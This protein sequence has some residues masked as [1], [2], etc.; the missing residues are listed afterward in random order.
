LEVPF[1]TIIFRHRETQTGDMNCGGKVVCVTGASGYIASWIVKLLLLRGYTVNATVRDPSLFPTL[2]LFFILKN[3]RL[4][5]LGTIM[6][7]TN[8]IKIGIWLKN[9]TES[10]QLCLYL[11]YIHNIQIVLFFFF[12]TTKLKFGT[13]ISCCVLND[14]LLIRQYFSDLYN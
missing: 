9:L 10:N 7:S 3:K 14:D 12:E 4:Q 5:L 13:L 11:N 2:S 8:R 1:K 6:S